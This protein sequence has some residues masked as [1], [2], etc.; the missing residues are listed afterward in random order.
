MQEWFAREV[1][2]AGRLR[3]FCFFVMF[4]VTFLFIR[5]SVRLI[6]RQV[7]WWPG[8]VTPGGLHIHH[9]VFGLVLMCLGGIGG[10]AVE[11]TRSWIAALAAG[12]FGVGAALV[13]DEFALVLHLD[14]VYCPAGR[15]R[16]RP[17]GAARLAVGAVALQGGLAQAPPR[18]LAGGPAAPADR[19]RQARSAGPGRGPPGPVTGSSGPA[20]IGHRLGG[21]TGFG[22]RPGGPPLRG[23]RR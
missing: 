19:A 10:L 23:R 12:L 13:L 18:H 17:P 6:R 5:F 16:R 14:D 7:R 8:N 20:A 2:A 4:L 3:M 15:D 1:M 11:D 22:D 9:V 21:P